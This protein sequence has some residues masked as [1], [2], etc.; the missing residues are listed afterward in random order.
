MRKLTILLTLLACLLIP[1]R[2]LADPPGPPMTRAPEGWVPEMLRLRLTN[3]RVEEATMVTGMIQVLQ[4]GSNGYNENEIEFGGH[5]CE[6]SWDCYPPT[7]PDVIAASTVEVILHV[8]QSHEWAEIKIW[9]WVFGETYTGRQ[10]AQRAIPWE[11]RYHRFVWRC[12][13]IDGHTLRILVWDYDDDGLLIDKTMTIDHLAGTGYLYRLDHAHEYWKSN[14]DTVTAVEFHEIYDEIEGWM[15]VGEAGFE[16][17]LWTTDESPDAPVEHLEAEFEWIRKHDATA[18]KTGTT[19]SVIQRPP[20]LQNTESYD[21]F[22]YLA[23][24][25]NNATGKGWAHALMWYVN[26]PPE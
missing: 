26:Y 1:A 10:V 19:L 20:A 12:E 18:P 25:L 8:K 6:Q 13:K 17:I 16:K 24:I 15:S 23:H 4:G 5:R 3:P 21:E 9:L 7:P 2:S 14:W 22:C 11:D